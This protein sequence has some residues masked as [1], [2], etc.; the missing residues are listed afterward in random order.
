[1]LMIQCSLQ[2]STTIGVPSASLA[3]NAANVE[4][5]DRLRHIHNLD[6]NALHA[7]NNQAKLI[8]PQSTPSK[9][10][11][12]EQQTMTT[13]T[14]TTVQ[15]GGSGGERKRKAHVPATGTPDEDDTAEE[16]DDAATRKTVSTQVDTDQLTAAT[17]KLNIS[18]AAPAS[19]G[20]APKQQT[21][22]APVVASNKPACGQQACPR[23]DVNAQTDNTHETALSLASQ[24]GRDEVVDLLCHN[25][26]NIEH[27]DRK[28]FTP[29]ILAATGGWV[30]CVNTLINSGAKLEAMSERTKDTALSLACSSGRKEVGDRT[31]T[32]NIQFI[33]GGRTHQSWCKHGT[34]KHQ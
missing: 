6:A 14:T 17:A 7:L 28:G 4:W 18:C 20:K 9:M 29:L 25:G 32:A 5:A 23:I 13:Q 11:Q 27:K 3:D 15:A 12:N 16:D 22:D 34:Q 10:K 8:S 2:L 19:T 33:G 31:C 26:A 21:A 1:M 30:N 24:H